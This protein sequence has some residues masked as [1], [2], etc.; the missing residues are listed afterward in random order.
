[1]PAERAP[2]QLQRIQHHRVHLNGGESVARVSAI[3]TDQNEALSALR[4]KTDR[5][6]TAGAI[7][8]ERFKVGLSEIRQLRD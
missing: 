3:N 7:V 1:V 4:V 8:V 5:A 2:E 6:A